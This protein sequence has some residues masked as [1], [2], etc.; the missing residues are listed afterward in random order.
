M[1]S[2]TIYAV[3]V[4]EFCLLSLMVNCTNQCKSH[5][6]TFKPCFALAFYL[7]THNCA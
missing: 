4:S 7:H 3:Q 5:Y 6:S 2:I 1:C